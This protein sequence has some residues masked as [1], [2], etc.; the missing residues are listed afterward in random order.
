MLLRK[1]EEALGVVRNGFKQ[2]SGLMAV[3]RPYIV[4]PEGG[5]RRVQRR[6]SGRSDASCRRPPASLMT[7]SEGRAARDWAGKAVRTAAD[8][9]QADLDEWG[10]ACGA[11]TAGPPG[12]GRP[13]VCFPHLGQAVAARSAGGRVGQ[14]AR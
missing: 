7:G 6:A 10:T 5:R 3:E 13:H 4:G 11:R 1:H 9:A 2:T 14:A 12:C 8:P